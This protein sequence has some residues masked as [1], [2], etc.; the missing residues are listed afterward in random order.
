MRLG[1]GGVMRK[2][3]LAVALLPALLL[4][5]AATGA[6]GNLDRSGKISECLQWEGQLYRVCYAYVVNASLGARLPFY[7][8]GSS[9]SEA[10]ARL[11]RF[12][13]ESRYD[14]KARMTIENEVDSWRSGPVDVS[15]PKI[16]IIDVNHKEG[17]RLATLV[18]RERWVVKTPE[19]KLLY[20][21]SGQFTVTLNETA[22]LITSKWIVVTIKPRK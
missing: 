8:Q 5:G 13:F 14:G 6:T 17:S 2:L 19:G 12:R 1:K 7:K 16:E 21:T 22:G 11:A 9:G 10:R 18:T 3:V 15:L 4:A 20:S